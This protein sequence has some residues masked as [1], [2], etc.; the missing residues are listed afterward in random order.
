[1]ALEAI[2][3]G[4]IVD[5]ND[6]AMYDQ[7]VI[8]RTSDILQGDLHSGPPQYY[9]P[10]NWQHNIMFYIAEELAD[11]SKRII[12]GHHHVEKLGNLQYEFRGL[13][14]SL[15]A[16]AETRDEIN[17]YIETIPKNKQSFLRYNHYGKTHNMANEFVR[18]FR[19]LRHQEISEIVQAYVDYEKCATADKAEAEIKASSIIEKCLGKAAADNTFDKV[20]RNLFRCLCKPHMLRA[21]HN[22]LKM[23][24]GY[25]VLLEW[26]SEW[27]N[28][29]LLWNHPCGPLKLLRTADANGFLP[30]YQCELDDPFEGTPRYLHLSRLFLENGEEI[31]QQANNTMSYLTAS[32]CHMMILQAW[33]R[34]IV[35]LNYPTSETPEELKRVLRLSN[36]DIDAMN[37]D[38]QILYDLWTKSQQAYEAKHPH[39]Y[40]D[41]VMDLQPPQQFV[42]KFEH[43]PKFDHVGARGYDLFQV[44]TVDG[45]FVTDDM[46]K[47]EI[48]RS[49]QGGS[50]KQRKN[51]KVLDVVIG[52]LQSNLENY[53]KE[54]KALNRERARNQLIFQKQVPEGV[55]AP[56]DLF[57]DFNE[58]QM[59]SIKN[60]FKDKLPKLDEWAY[61]DDVG[62]GKIAGASLWWMDELINSVEKARRACETIKS[63]AQAV[64]I[65]VHESDTLEQTR[66]DCEEKLRLKSVPETELADLR[67]KHRNAGIE[68]KNLFPDYQE[69][70]VEQKYEVEDHIR[71]I[72]REL[73]EKEAKR[74]N[75]LEI[76]KNDKPTDEQLAQE[77]LRTQIAQLEAKLR[78]LKNAL[79]QK[80]EEATDVTNRRVEELLQER[81]YTPQLSSTRRWQWEA[82]EPWLQRVVQFQE[83]L[84]ELKGKVEPL[85]RKRR[86]K[87]A[88]EEDTKLLQELEN[89]IK[90]KELELAHLKTNLVLEAE[91]FGAFERRGIWGS[92]PL[93]HILQEMQQIEEKLQQ[94]Q[95]TNNAIL[96]Q[97]KQDL[98]QLEEEQRAAIYHAENAE[99][100]ADEM[101]FEDNNNDADAAQ[102]GAEEEE[103]GAEEAGAKEAGAEAAGAE[104]KGAGKKKKSK[105]HQKESTLEKT[106]RFKREAQQRR[107]DDKE[108]RTV[109][110][111]HQNQGAARGPV[112]PIVRG[113]LEHAQARSRANQHEPVKIN[114]LP[115][116]QTILTNRKNRYSIESQQLQYMEDEKNRVKKYAGNLEQDLLIYAEWIKNYERAKTNLGPGK[117]ENEITAS[118]NYEDAKKAVKD[119]QTE[120]AVLKDANKGLSRNAVKFEGLKGISKKKYD[121]NVRQIEKLQESIPELK[122]IETSMK[123]E[124]EKIINSEARSQYIADYR[125]ILQALDNQFAKDHNDQSIY[126]IKELYRSKTKRREESVQDLKK[127]S[128]QLENFEIKVVLNAME[129]YRH[130]RAVAE[131]RARGGEGGGHSGVGYGGNFNKTQEYDDILEWWDSLTPEEQ[132]KEARTNK[133]WESDDRMWNDLRNQ[134]W[135]DRQIQQEMERQAQNQRDQMG[136]LQENRGQRPKNRQN[137]VFGGPKVPGLNGPGKGQQRAQG[138]DKGGGRGV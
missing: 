72:E 74:A 94:Q 10:T 60:Y 104:Q 57:K 71:D 123:E 21:L 43:V 137:T 129:N 28:M 80:K 108:R 73:E 130:A 37:K 41:S 131:G 87:K 5:E 30:L 67:T 62:L 4:N 18:A 81:Q 65:L 95:A 52:E 24:E 134:G 102:D 82:L 96:P 55:T 13:H 109:N 48:R 29:L 127:K 103:A 76:I 39:E 114:E 120:I 101:D 119:A 133:E 66:H 89:E 42:P 86:R 132:Q 12:A 23:L 38:E 2:D 85:A 77:P 64:N 135:G 20:H 136:D 9:W 105:P 116:F 33:F 97:L 22:G 75:T 36:E 91:D 70:L 6:H 8:G 47:G 111:G 16:T 88:S 58:E 25:V 117:P 115:S 11:L 79:I 14:D 124:L 50:D 100:W 121:Q 118:Q 35:R 51:L 138:Q 56:T 59:K 32:D 125:E 45:T 99:R 93:R 7:I 26:T 46:G 122:Q 112:N 17:N 3:M 53:K 1:M 27:K 110:A 106:D 61:M 126:E 31:S 68:L 90:I 40:K 128:K 15:M 49:W 44:P 83:G 107:E 54:L 69:H 84:N 98:I 113:T 92:A 19:H 78:Y 34:P 63:F